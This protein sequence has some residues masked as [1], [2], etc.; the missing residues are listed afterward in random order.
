MLKNYIT[1]AWRNLRKS[2]MYSAINITGL[3]AGMAIAMLIGLWIV[4]EWQFD[5]QFPNYKRIAL[6]EQNVYN[7]GE[8]GTGMNQPFP[9]AAVLR[10]DYSADIKYAAMCTW[11]QTHV[12]TL[13]EKRLNGVGVYCEPALPEM[14]TLKMQA[15]SHKLTDPA[16]ILLSVSQAKACFGKENPLNKTL[17]IDNKTAVV[18]T[19]VYKDM[20]RNSTF[21]NVNFIMPWAL[22]ARL[23]ELDKR[24][25]PWRSNSYRA[26]V[27]IAEHTTMEKVSGKIK[28]VKLKNIH[29]DELSFHPQLFLHPMSRWH[30]YAEFKNGINVGGF[31]KY[32]WLFGISGVF[33]LLLACI[34]FMNLSTARSQKRAKEVGIR[35]A[36]G[37]QRSQLIWQFFSESLLMVM[38][39]LLAALLLVAL[40]LP[41]FNEVANKQMSILWASP[42]F[43]AICLGF[44]LITGLIAGSYPAF[45]LSAFRPVKVLKGT[46][47]VGRYAAMPRKVLVVLQFTVS[48]ILIIVTIVVFRQ[49]QFAQNRPIG[50]DRNG[51]VALPMYTPAIHEQ[52]DVVRNELLQTGAVE[53]MAEC[54]SPV[55]S[56]WNTSSG[57]NWEGKDPG[58]ALDFPSEPVSYDFGKTIGW[59]FVA[60]RD[61]SRSFG[62]D[63]T[64]F[65]INEAAVKFMGLKDP[66]GKIVTWDDEPYHIIGVIKDVIA[67]SPYAPVRP[68][69]YHMLRG[70]P[71]IRMIVKIDPKVSTQ[72][73]LAKIEAVF[74]RY[75]PTQPFDYQ[76]VDQDYAAKFGDEQRFGKLATIFSILAILISCLGLFGMAS[77][78][79]E[80]RTKEI[81]VRKVLGATLFSLW[82]LLST[83]FVKLVI[84]ALAIAC[85]VA[86]YAMSGW[87]QQYAYRTT[88]PWWIFP[89]AAVATLFITFLTVSYQAIKAALMN[90]V[91]SLRTE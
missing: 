82:G 70:G 87:L 52:F 73:A 48:V 21:S 18:V 89:A 45:Y 91:K 75:N 63:S 13:G 49:I 61:F 54:W 12:L 81:G 50:Y 14:L 41:L 84:I 17:L 76:F 58:M 85:P 51:L 9:L 78:M 86:Y 2:K 31:I 33:I 1:I 77:F 56:V 25:N 40:L 39:A 19:G 38:L 37:S 59:Q 64:A 67:E 55:T 53:N 30:L 65:V 47:R 11:D 88:I 3:A 29:K 5:K 22:Y 72:T 57:F 35:K 43:W 28:D 7:N 66:V 44:S 16:T 8:I 90:P 60:G 32:V 6:V 46:F 20:P 74:K 42:V 36:I 24:D 69:V 26:I 71:G 68:A 4:D 23:E 80:Q 34:N 62:T 10:K 15:G 83:D 27:Q 79:A